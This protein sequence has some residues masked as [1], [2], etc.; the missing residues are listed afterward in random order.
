MWFIL[1]IIFFFNFFV[2]DCRGGI[3]IRSRGWFLGSVIVFFVLNDYSVLFFFYL[4]IK[5]LFF[6]LR[7]RM[8]VGISKFDV[9]VIDVFEV[10]INYLLNL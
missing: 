3:G 7:V 2:V 9:V 6:G 8:N 10:L 5:C 4:D 1:D